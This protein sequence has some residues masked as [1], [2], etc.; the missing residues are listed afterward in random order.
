MVLFSLTLQVCSSV[1]PASAKTDSKEHV[2]F[3]CSEKLGRL[4][5]KGLH[6]I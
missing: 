4:P 5:E 1:F 6:V 3:E 2:S